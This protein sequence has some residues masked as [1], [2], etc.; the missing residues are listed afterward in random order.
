MHSA[1]EKKAIDPVV[2]DV[3]QLVQIVDY[4]VILSGANRRQVAT[5]IDEIEERLRDEGLRPLR[6]EGVSE[7]EWALLD[8]GDV[9]IHIFRDEV[10]HFYDLERLWADAPRRTVAES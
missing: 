6:R 4:F 5:L 7:A 3:S 8:Y 1:A 10:R 2:L 9:V